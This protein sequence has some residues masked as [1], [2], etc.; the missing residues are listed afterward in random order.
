M[1]KARICKKWDLDLN[2]EMKSEDDLARNQR[3]YI[4]FAVDHSD[5][6]SAKCYATEWLLTDVVPEGTYSA[7]E[8]LAG[9]GVQSTILQNLFNLSEHVVMERDLECYEHLK[10][11]GLDAVHADANKSMFTHTDY[12]VKLADFPSSSVLSVQKKWKGFRNLFASNPK[13]VVWTDT[14]TSYPMKI[15]GARYAQIFNSSEL[16]TRED[17]VKQY[18]LWIQREFGYSVVKA[19]FRGKNAVYFAATP[20]FKTTE[21]KAF[22]LDQYSDGFEVQ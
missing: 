19:A 21:T 13:L 8:Y 12:D 10:N 3:S 16:L 9:I 2:F 18:A 14:A 20:G 15:H 11:L 4:H 5:M 17:Y 6:V 1:T 7:V 22:P